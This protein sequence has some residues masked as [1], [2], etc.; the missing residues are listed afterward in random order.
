[1]YD[2]YHDTEVKPEATTAVIE[3]LMIGGR[4]LK[5]CW[6][7]NKYQDNKLENCCILLVIYLNWTSKYGLF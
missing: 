2:Y 6:A 1:M 3:L 5:T 7:I 4:T